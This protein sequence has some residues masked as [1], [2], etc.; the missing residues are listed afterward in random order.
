MTGLGNN[1]NNDTMVKTKKFQE[2]LKQ[3]WKAHVNPVYKAKVFENGIELSDDVE[4]EKNKNTSTHKPNQNEKA[5][6]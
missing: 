6:L 5:I 2:L 3:D 1:L 4:S